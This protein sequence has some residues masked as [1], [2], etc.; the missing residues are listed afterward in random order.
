MTKFRTMAA[1]AGL[2][3]ALTTMGAHAQFIVTHVPNYPPKTPS[4]SA[5]EHCSDLMGFMRSIRTDEIAAIGH[6]QPIALIPV[7]EE[8]SIVARNNYGSLFIDGNAE[9]LRMPIARNDALM[10]ALLGKDYDQHDVVSVRFGGNDSV[11][12]YVHQRYMR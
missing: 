1:I 12:L 4:V 8:L 10:S 7:C 11:I 2:V 9:K 3:T 6:H 5:N